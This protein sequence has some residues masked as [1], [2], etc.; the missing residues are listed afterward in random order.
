MVRPFIATLLSLGDAPFP[1]RLRGGWPVSRPT[2]CHA[3]GDRALTRINIA[4]P[5]RNNARRVTPSKARNY[6]G[7]ACYV[8]KSIMKGKATQSALGRPPECQDILAGRA[9]AMPRPSVHKLASPRQRVRSP[10]GLF[11]LVADDMG[12]RV[13]RKLPREMRFVPRP[14]SK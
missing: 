2:L 9:L 13:L 10:V 14:I 5:W 8:S 1:I 3:E 7:Y 12:E 11:G 4:F 6:A